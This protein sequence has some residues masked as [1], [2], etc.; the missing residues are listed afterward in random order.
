M[1]SR[2][3]L[4]L[5]LHAWV[6]HEEFNWLFK[7]QGNAGAGIWGCIALKSRIFPVSPLWPGVQD[8]FLPVYAFFVPGFDFH[9]GLSCGIHTWKH[10]QSCELVMFQAFALTGWP[11]WN[12][13]LGELLFF[14]QP[15]KGHCSVAFRSLPGNCRRYWWM[16]LTIFPSVLTLKGISLRADPF[17]FLFLLVVTNFE[18]IKAFLLKK[19]HAIFYTQSEGNSN[20]RVNLVELFGTYLAYLCICWRCTKWGMKNCNGT[21]PG[22]QWK[23]FIVVKIYLFIWAGAAAH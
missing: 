2:E 9:F 15:L 23:V 7:Q 16:R 3:S 20:C 8:P 21:S 6:R 4:A 1:W 5:M 13:M 19:M 17:V 14:K 12:Q 18:L 11:F 10:F 22:S